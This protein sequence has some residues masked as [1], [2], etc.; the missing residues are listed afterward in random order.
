MR[1]Q[2]N[3]F[4][5][6]NIEIL[7]AFLEYLW[8]DPIKIIKIVY[9]R[10]KNF[11]VDFVIHKSKMIRMK[12]KIERVADDIAIRLKYTSHYEQD[13]DHYD[14]CLFLSFCY[15]CPEELELCNQ[16]GLY[17]KED[18]KRFDALENINEIYDYQRKKNL[19]G[20]NQIFIFNMA[21]VKDH[22]ND[23]VLDQILQDFDKAIK[24]VYY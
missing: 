19:L 24:R 23:K 21:R 17:K 12:A 3:N 10:E 7:R 2:A 9:P 6:D 1:E 8:K 5:M 4:F 22:C 18:M 14:A 20:H 11:T 13:F 16:Y 15:K